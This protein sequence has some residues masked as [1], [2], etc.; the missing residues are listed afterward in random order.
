[1][2]KLLSNC[3]KSTPALVGIVFLVSGVTVKPVGANEPVT[4]ASKDPDAML[5]EITNYNK[6]APM[7]Q[8]T[9]VSQL[10]DVSPTDWAYEALRSLVERYGCIVGYPD[11]T[12]R[13]NRALSRYEFAAGLNACMEQ[14]ER[15]LA[16][17][18]AVLREDIELLK[19]LM[20]EF[21][22]ELAYLGARVDNLE[23]RVAFLEDHQFST[24]TKL[25]G[26]ALIAATGQGGPEFKLDQFYNLP[27][28]SPIP[29][30]GDN[31]LPGI[32]SAGIPVAPDEVDDQFTLSYRAKLTLDT[33]F[34]GKDKLR[35]R[36]QTRNVP[37][38][39]RALGP[40]GARI[41][42]DG[43]EG[44]DIALDRLFYRFPWG[45]KATV[46]IAATI[47][48]HDIYETFN[49]FLGDD[50][51][52]SLSRFGRY[53]PFIYRTSGDTGVG[54]KYKFNETFD[55]TA[56][57][58]AGN[59]GDPTQGNGIFNGS[60]GTGLQLGIHPTDNFSFGL[61]YIHSYFPRGEVNLTGSTGSN[62]NANVGRALDVLSDGVLGGA[63]GGFRGSRDPFNGAATTS[64]NFG[65][66]GSWRISENIN[67]SAW[68]GYAAATAQSRD[69][70]GVNRQGDFT[71]L[72]TWNTNFSFI[73]LFTDNGDVLSIA[74]GQLPRAGNVDGTFGRDFGQSW[75]VEGQYKY[76]I[77]DNITLTPGVYAL[78]N[79]N[80][81]DDSRN[82]TIVVGI[83]RAVFTF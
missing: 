36:L 58:L 29:G 64:E 60:F 48:A 41:N 65:I 10:R 61:A 6:T 42:F 62:Y 83:L 28:P 1:M 40:D 31:A 27:G 15:L 79:P 74:G 43:E 35:T 32:N 47:P 44:N 72:W 76:P 11:R 49:P 73:D 19:R 8:V 14:M 9:S 69:D 57:Y 39:D 82:D 22:T 55:V 78:F 26:L 7:G 3:L 34:T 4:P 30:I 25:S 2:V 54:F 51:L 20:K 81:S 77:R 5:R 53:N 38:L 12:Y 33:S 24:T 17:T 18:E 45:D 68:L 56:S 13:G 46:W 67:W 71:E 23:G 63:R 52:G 16:Q 80:N 70:G 59:A 75:I 21:E 66:Q 50:D 37:R